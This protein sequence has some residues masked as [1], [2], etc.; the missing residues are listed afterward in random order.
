MLVFVISNNAIRAHILFYYSSNTAEI[1]RAFMI[2]NESNGDSKCFSSNII[3]SPF[4]VLIFVSFY[5]N[6]E[7]C[8]KEDNLTA[9]SEKNNNASHLMVKNLTMPFESMSTLVAIISSIVKQMMNCNDRTSDFNF[10]NRLAMMFLI[11][12]A[13][14]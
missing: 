7:E 6:Q 11:R 10:I 13:S 2:D 5:Q 12:I 9:V 14:E 1:K 4:D 3:V 8:K